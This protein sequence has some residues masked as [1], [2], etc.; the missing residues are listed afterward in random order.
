MDGM[1]ARLAGKIDSL[2]ASVSKN[3]ETI[4][5]LTDMVNKNTVNLARL[6]AE[7]HNRLDKKVAEIVRDQFAV[8][9]QQ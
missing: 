2:E 5:V 6:E 8:S 9:A 1:E 3:K 7:M 4:V